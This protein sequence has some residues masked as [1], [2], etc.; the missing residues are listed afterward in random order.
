MRDAS[1]EKDLKHDLSDI[2][3][4]LQKKGNIDARIN[5]AMYALLGLLAVHNSLLEK[6]IVGEHNVLGLDAAFAL[7]K[8]HQKYHRGIVSAVIFERLFH[9]L[10]EYQINRL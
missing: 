7:I 2:I 8:S 5:P 6:E 3:Q 1:T 9:V 4:N 10:K